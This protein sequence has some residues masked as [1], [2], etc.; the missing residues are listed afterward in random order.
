M[1]QRTIG[2]LG[3]LGPETT[4]EFYL[5]LVRMATVRA[6]PPACIWSLPL[7]L[8]KESEYISTGKHLGYYFSLL[9]R[10]ALALQKAG[11]DR[12]VIPCNTVH[13][14]H[15]RLAA[16]VDVPVTNLIEIVGSTVQMRGWKKVFLLATSRTL[17]TQLYQNVFARRGISIVVPNPEDQRKLDSL[18][19]GL[20][21][22]KSST[23]HQE[24]LERMFSHSRVKHIVLG[25]TDLQLLFPA[26]DN[27]V[28]SMNALAVHT[29]REIKVWEER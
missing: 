17:Q 19:Q 22:N 1:K 2:I 20:L 26:P 13:E 25:C 8:K 14:F 3:G 12:L 9:K 21:G 23:G 28:D 5:D 18:I 27:V 11:C 16:S 15:F 10:G 24:Y 7:D 6:R 4:A 29:A